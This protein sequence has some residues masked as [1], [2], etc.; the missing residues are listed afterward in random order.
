MLNEFQHGTLQN[1]LN[2]IVYAVA[3]MIVEGRHVNSD[4]NASWDADSQRGL[5]KKAVKYYVKE[6]EHASFMAKN[7]LNKINQLNSQSMVGESQ[8]MLL[9]QS[10]DFIEDEHICDSDLKVNYFLF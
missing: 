7:L 8:K 3:L 1:D 10:D 5:M 2:E 9:N 6:G 4:S